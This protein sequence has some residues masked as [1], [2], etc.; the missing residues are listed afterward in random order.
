MNKRVLMIAYHYP[1]VQGS[2]GLQR[3]L[4]F[5]AY[6]QEFGWQP[7]VLTVRPGAYSQTS[8][9]QV[10]EIPDDIVV[11]RTFALDAARHLALRGIYPSFLALPDRW[12]SWWLTAVPAG[13]QLIRRYRPRVIWSTYPIAT[14]HM[15]GRTLH[16]LTG[17]PWVADF[18]DGMVDDTYPAPGTTARSLFQWLERRFVTSCD[19]AVLTTPGSRRMYAQRYGSLPES[20]WSVIPNGYDENNFSQAESRALPAVVGREKLVLVHSGLLYPSSRDPRAFF[21]A[22]RR[23]VASGALSPRVIKIVLRASGHDSYYQRLI[24]E[25]NLQDIVFLEPAVGYHEA[26]AEMLAADGLLVFQASDCNHLI[27]AK[28]YEYLR[29]GRPILALTDPQGDSAMLLREM[30][31]DTVVP[32]DSDIRI[33]EG[34]MRF[35]KDVR[36]GTAPSAA[37]A[38][39]AC[40]SRRSLTADLAELFDSLA[41]PHCRSKG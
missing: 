35:V 25:H 41:A 11:R 7:L 26:L 30:G 32:L 6:L 5:S 4:K 28:L 24:A 38:D 13:L 18:R 10:G 9:T 8:P 27:P 36:A 40:Y 15:V 3:T 16:R 14:A 31:I 2:S 12:A 21:S 1:P 39:V 20:R 34:L 22:V 33:A 23:L 17:L 19:R 37:R 29:A